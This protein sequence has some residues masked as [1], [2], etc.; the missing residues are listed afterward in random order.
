M[1]Q[2]NFKVTG[3]SDG[4]WITLSHSL[5]TT[6]Q[7]W[8]P[9]L[10]V[11]EQQFQ[12]LRYDTRGHGGSALTQPGFDIDNLAQDVIDLWDNLGIQESHFLG[13]SLGGMTGVGLA[14]NHAERLNSLI[15]C[16]CR[17]DAPDAFHQ[18]WD[19][20]IARVTEGGLD[21]VVDEILE[22]WI[23]DRTQ[24]TRAEEQAR[25]FILDTDPAAYLGCAGAL[26]TLNYK[27]DLS[28][29]GTPTLYIVGEND[30]PHP[31]AMEEM[32]SLTPGARLICL[33][34]AAHLANLEQPTAFNKAMISFLSQQ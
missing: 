3:K 1:A 28:E 24:I 30:G 8:D 6:M 4:S 29:I 26:K 31:A 33:K 11:L 17:V 2:L 22:T 13:L 16:D 9:Q 20:R 25:A 7:M 10:A 12:V 21:T 34:D 18:L 19:R 23:S 14:L 27:K 32:A 5:A 15:A